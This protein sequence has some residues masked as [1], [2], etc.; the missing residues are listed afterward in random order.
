MFERATVV[1]DENLRECVCELN[2]MYMTKLILYSTL[3]S[4]VIHSSVL[5]I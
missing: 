5:N 3:A 2:E 1:I 4:T